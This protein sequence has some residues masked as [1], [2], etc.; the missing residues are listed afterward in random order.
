MDHD[1]KM[2]HFI[3]GGL[4]QLTWFIFQPGSWGHLKILLSF[5]GSVWITKKLYALGNT[6]PDHVSG[7]KSSQRQSIQLVQETPSQSR[8]PTT[9]IKTQKIVVSR[10]KLGLIRAFLV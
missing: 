7:Q 2:Y 3:L 8:V 5:L 4:I 9:K 1:P 10:S 6:T